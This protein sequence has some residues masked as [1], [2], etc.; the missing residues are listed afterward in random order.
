MR[1]KP[2]GHSGAKE[3]SAMKTLAYLACA[4]CFC[5]VGVSC[6]QSSYEPSQDQDNSSVVYFNS[7]ESARDTL[8]W[9]GITEQMFVRDPAPTGGDWSLHIGGGCIQPTAHIVLPPHGCAGSYRLSFWG[10]L[11]DSVQRGVIILAVEAGGEQREEMALVVDSEQWAFY[12]SKRPLH[13]SANQEL[14]LEI[15]IGGIVPASM[16]IDCI[17]VERFK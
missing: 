6:D 3:M 9:E 7:F 16:S 2:P 17:K 10:K 1:Q 13:R 15:M 5:C 11:D 4:A 8:G 12:R 14:R